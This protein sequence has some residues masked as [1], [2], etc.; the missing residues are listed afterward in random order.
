MKK[1]ELV[2]RSEGEKKVARE[3]FDCLEIFIIAIA[4]VILIFTF[5][6]RIGSVDGN[7]MNYTLFH[8]DRIIISHIFYKPKVG[9]IVVINERKGNDPRLIG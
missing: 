5:V 3:I 2:I 4:V 8:G 1:I 9:D 7:S 6:L